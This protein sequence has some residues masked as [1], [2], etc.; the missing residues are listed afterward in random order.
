MRAQSKRMEIIAEN[1][2]NVDSISTTPG[3][4]PYKRKLIFFK[5]KYDA[6]TGTF[7]VMVQKVARDNKNQFKL[8]YDPSNP[9]AD[10]KGYIKKPNVNTLIESEDSKEAQRAYEANLKMYQLS[11]KLMK[12]TLDSLR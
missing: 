3:G 11:E 12:E 9:A 6:N 2:A 8:E 1:Q 5:N 7:K 10:A 4:D